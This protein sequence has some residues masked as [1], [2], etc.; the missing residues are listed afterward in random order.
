MKTLNI[1]RKKINKLWFKILG[2]TETAIVTVILGGALISK[3]F[4]S[5]LISEGIYV[6]SMAF[7]VVKLN[8]TLIRIQLSSLHTQQQLDFA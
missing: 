4:E 6:V 5:K 3:E 2:V 7:P 1:L 8:K